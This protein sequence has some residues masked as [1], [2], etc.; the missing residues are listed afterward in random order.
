[1]NVHKVVLAIGLLISSMWASL[2]LI[3]YLV[4]A[5]VIKHVA[6]S[7]LRTLLGMSL[8]VLWLISWYSTLRLFSSWLLKR[9]SPPQHS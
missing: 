3:L 8:Y 7:V 1:M 4:E 9:R 6:V 5:F 2:M